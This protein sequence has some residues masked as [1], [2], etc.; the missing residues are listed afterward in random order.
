[1]TNNVSPKISNV[2]SK[3]KI[4]SQRNQSR[5]IDR[6]CQFLIFSASLLKSDASSMINVRSLTNSATH[7]Q[8]IPSFVDAQRQPS[9]KQ[10]QL[11]EI[12]C[13]T[14]IFKVSLMIINI[15]HCKE[16]YHSLLSRQCKRKDTRRQLIDTKCHLK[17]NE[18]PPTDRHCH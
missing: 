12:H 16:Q 15:N 4:P 9:N 2:S 18:C 7:L 5:R 10:R 3:I 8:A 11:I 1:M 13:Q 14:L 17:E 6:Q